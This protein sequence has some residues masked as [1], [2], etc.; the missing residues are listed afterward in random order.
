MNIKNSPL[1]LSR[2]SKPLAIVAP[3]VL[4]LAGCGGHDEDPEAVAVPAELTFP[5]YQANDEDGSQLY[6]QCKKDGTTLSGSYAFFMSDGEGG[7]E[8]DIFSGPVTGTVSA[9]GAVHVTLTNPYD[10][11]QPPVVLEG[12]QS[13]AGLTLHDV[14]T[15]EE[16][17]VFTPLTAE[18]AVHT[19]GLGQSS[20][21]FTIKTTTP[22]GGEL[23][24]GTGTLAW[25]LPPVYEHTGSYRFFTK[26]SGYS[27]IFE[28]RWPNG[29][30]MIDVYVKSSIF[31]IHEARFWV[32]T[33]SRPTPLA[34]DSVY[35][36][37]DDE[38]S[39]VAGRID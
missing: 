32:R 13:A 31:L 37:P 39:P 20:P 38:W 17:T 24:A 12:T 15:P 25:A 16:D 10:E 28:T 8:P 14:E 36:N 5:A 29:W 30:S 1:C 7:L 22:S 11:S 26:A 19:R 34:N 27:N 33:D 3:L 4:V 21:K 23:T 35:V 2:V 18:D 9:E 6:L